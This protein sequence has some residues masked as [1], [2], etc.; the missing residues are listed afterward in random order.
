MEGSGVAVLHRPGRVNGWSRRSTG[1]AV[2]ESALREYVTG[3]RTL[4]RP[5]WLE[6]WS[7]KAGEWG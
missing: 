3:G 2:R 7:M 4:K 1:G 5:G 6:G